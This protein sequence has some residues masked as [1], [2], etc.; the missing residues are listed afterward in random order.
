MSDFGKNEKRW[1]GKKCYFIYHE[2]SNAIACIYY[3]SASSSNK[4]MNILKIFDVNN[5]IRESRNQKL[6]VLFRAKAKDR[7]HKCSKSIDL[8][9]DAC[10]NMRHEQLRSARPNK[11][12]NRSAEHFL[13]HSMSRP[14]DHAAFARCRSCA[15]KYLITITRANYSNEK[16]SLASDM[17]NGLGPST[18]SYVC[19]LPFVSNSW[20]LAWKYSFAENAFQKLCGLRNSFWAEQQKHWMQ[21]MSRECYYIQFPS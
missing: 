11:I 2:G 6:F 1:Q 4:K 20:S 7:I 3:V 10:S 14:F 15:V 17:K 9:T 21:S 16:W 13:T 19:Y 8:G 18:T 12:P 5:Y